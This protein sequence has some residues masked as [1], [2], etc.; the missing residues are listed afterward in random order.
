MPKFKLVKFDDDDRSTSDDDKMIEIPINMNESVPNN[1]QIK[2]AKKGNTN[3]ATKKSGK[4]K[5]KP[6]NK[7][8][9]FFKSFFVTLFLCLAFAGAII[10]A[11]DK[12]FY[13]ND[14]IITL[15]DNENSKTT[16]DDIK[17]GGKTQYNFAF[18][19]VDNE[20]PVN[21][22]TDFMMIGSY[23]KVDNKIR[24]MSVPRDTIAYM[25]QNR[26]D[27]LRKN[28]VTSKMRSSGLMKMTEINH[29]ATDEYGTSYLLAQLE[30]DFQV[31]FDFYVKFNVDGFIYLVDA[32]GGVP[33]DVPQR[34]YYND[35]TQNLLIDVQ[36]GYQTLNGK[37]AEGV[38]RYRTN[39]ALGDLDRIKVQQEFIKAFVK[40]LT[41]LTNI[42]KTLP[43]ILQTASK[44]ASTNFKIS[45]ISEFLP[46]ITE[47]SSE[48]LIMYQM[49]YEFVTIGGTEFVK[50]LQPDTSEM[51]DE[52]FYPNN[53]LVEKVPS[54]NLDINVLNGTY[55]SKLAS[56]YAST[57]EE[58][59]F[60]VSYVGDYDG[61]KINTTKIYVKEKGYGEDL[62]PYFNNAK[63][64]HDENI[65]CDIQIVLGTNEVN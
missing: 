17:S 56:K 38:V 21:P 60:T 28:G 42:Y 30:E 54:T 45:Q 11:Y 55:T 39:Y 22:R 6:K 51:I 13:V 58:N 36:K 47:F 7:K 29:H 15:Y 37:Q 41:S 27:D 16:L 65:P 14:P 2:R 12:I 61:E 25:P 48:N 59:G 44:Y 1:P 9:T 18:F 57:L 8:G 10:F 32:I 5:R 34:M 24:L 23:D 19:G 63:I 33:F 50:P 64:V 40:Q 43:A 26:I 62:L 52:I 3:N 49:P 4:K 31:D 35:P 46:F 53:S 20:S